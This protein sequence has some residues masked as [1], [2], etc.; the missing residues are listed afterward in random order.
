MGPDRSPLKTLLL[1]GLLALG[2]CLLAQPAAAQGETCA[3][4]YYVPAI[5]DIYVGGRENFAQ[6]AITLSI[7]NISE[8]GA[9]T[10][11]R[12]D[13]FNTKGAKLR[14]LIEGPVEVKPLETAQYFV[15]VVDREGGG[16]AN[17]IVEITRDAATPAPGL[18]SVMFGS[19]GQRGISLAAGGRRV[20]GDCG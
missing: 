8:T 13:Y 6:L 12:V 18:D 17:F 1:A 5:S 7:R 16:G 20:Q 2:P 14:E 11:T 15:D 3:E 4:T 19:R 10:V 9:L